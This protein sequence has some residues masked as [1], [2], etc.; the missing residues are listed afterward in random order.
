MFLFTLMCIV[1]I[2]SDSSSCSYDCNFLL[3]S[4]ARWYRAPELLF[5]AKLY[6]ASVDIWAI[7]CIF[8]ELLMR[9]PLFRGNSDIDQLGKI[10]SVL[11]TPTEAQWPGMKAL[12]DYVEY[13]EMKP[14]NLR[15]VVFPH[16]SNT[17]SNST[18]ASH[19][20]HH[21]NDALDLLSLMLTYN[22]AS[23]P[24]ASQVI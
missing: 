9:R 14:M 24:S 11:G 3:F 20:E 4:F 7:G 12:P 19:M 15:S 23:R 21:M 2:S 5:G 6:G 8:A 16:E 18:S 17:N 22:P 13:A 10:F 1:I